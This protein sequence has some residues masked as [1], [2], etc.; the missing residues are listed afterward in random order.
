[1]P[2]DRSVTTITRLPNRSLTAGPGPIIPLRRN[3]S[4]GAN[5]NLVLDRRR[6]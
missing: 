5:G 2:V 6:I 1:M 4:G 3:I